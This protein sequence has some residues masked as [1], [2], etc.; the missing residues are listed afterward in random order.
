MAGTKQTAC[1]WRYSG[2]HKSLSVV[3]SNACD[4]GQAVYL[5][6]FRPQ[7]C[8]CGNYGDPT[9]ECRCSHFDI[10]R[11]MSRISGPLLDRIDIHIEVPRVPY[12]E[13]RDTRAG[14]PS[15]AIRE[16]VIAARRLQHER[17]PGTTNATMTN[18]QIQQHCKLDVETEQLLEQAMGRH[19][20]SAR[21][22]TR[23]LKMARTI[24]DLD[25]GGPVQV[26]HVTEAIQ[27]RTT[28]RRFWQ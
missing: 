21:S 25:G 22:Y 8:K 12:R 14:E 10:R 5:S 1:A 13:L 18:R 20:F 3:L 9:R 7:R 15:A 28:E 24:A 23:I 4:S 26:Q 16:R 19:A 2:R 27:Y 17:F 6:R 11:Y